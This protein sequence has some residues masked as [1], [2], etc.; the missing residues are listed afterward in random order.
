MTPDDAA[1]TPANDT[2]TV[3][4]YL[5]RVVAAATPAST[6]TYT[7]YW[8][9]MVE[10]W[11]DQPVNSIR[12]TDVE[13][14]QRDCAAHARPRERNY[15]G[16]R[17]A[18]ENANTAARAFFRRAEADGIIPAGSSPAHQ[19]PK[20]RRLPST[21]R[22]LLPW[23][24]QA[25]TEIAR[26]TGNDVV[27]DSLLLRIHTETACR[28]GGALALRLAD[29][30][31]DNGLILLREKGETM[32][33]QPITRTLAGRL[34]D[35]AQIRGA[36]L[37]SDQLLRYRNGRP[38]TSRRYDHLWQRIGEHL[39]WVA[40]QGISTHWL[41]HTTLTWV[42]RNFSYGIARAYA[43]HTDNTGPATTT[44]IKADIHAVATALSALT[45]EPHPL[46]LSPE[47]LGF[48]T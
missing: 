26:T 42:E 16:G 44:Y 1:A 12:A 39:P 9:R 46:A 48:L 20:P 34:A 21:R 15:R 40:A 29:L 17:H 3:R 32:R 14:L 2:P 18:G 25:I 27:L 36:T 10:L 45:G 13:A 19:V 41:R 23:E 4:Q 30:D 33:W 37:P 6:R 5:P 24:L 11:G 31:T 43:G 47:E 7:T 22:A 28:R 38:I 35:H 8:T